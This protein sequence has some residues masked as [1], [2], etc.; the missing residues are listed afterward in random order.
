MF[1][2]AIVILTTYSTTGLVLLLSQSAVYLFNEFK[3]NKWL[4]P[5]VFVLCIPIYMIFSQNVEE[6]IQ[7]EKEASFQK[8]YFRP[9]YFDRP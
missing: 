9:P 8:R 4:T 1:L 2:T 7:G 5:F 3:T 6:K